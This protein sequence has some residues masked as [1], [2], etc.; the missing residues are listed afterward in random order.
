MLLLCPPVLLMKRTKLYLCH[1]LFQLTPDQQT[2][3]DEPSGV[4]KVGYKPIDDHCSEST[5]G[6]PTADGVNQFRQAKL[7]EYFNI[8]KLFEQ[9]GLPFTQKVLDRGNVFYAAL[10]KW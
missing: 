2:A 7:K 10:L 1:S 4:I 8:K 6:G 3:F 9:R 5:L